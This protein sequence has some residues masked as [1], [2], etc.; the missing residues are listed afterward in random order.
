MGEPEAEVF[1]EAIKTI[2]RV[3][4]LVSVLENVIGILRVWETVEE[5]LDK[6]SGYLHCRVII[7]P[8]KLGD[9]TQQRRVYI[10]LI[11]KL[12]GCSTVVHVSLLFCCQ[13]YVLHLFLGVFRS[14]GMVCGCECVM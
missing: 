7:D 10:L 6:L 2:Y 14:L 5:Y 13:H 1:R 4:P 3:K 8:C 9:C 12:F 11:H